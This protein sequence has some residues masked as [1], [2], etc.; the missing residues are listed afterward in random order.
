MDRGPTLSAGQF[1]Q[2]IAAGME[3]GQ[4]IEGDGYDL[5]IL[6]IIN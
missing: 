3:G 5:N 4:P 6:P 1:V 2:A